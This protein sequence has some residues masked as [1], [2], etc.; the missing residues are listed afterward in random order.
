MAADSNSQGVSTKPDLNWATV[1]DSTVFVVPYPLF[2]PAGLAEKK[3]NG[4]DV[5]EDGLAFQIKDKDYFRDKEKVLVCID[6]F[7]MGSNRLYFNHID[8]YGTK[9]QIP[10]TKLGDAQWKRAIIQLEKDSF[11]QRASLYL[12]SDFYLDASMWA[13]RMY[14]DNLFISRI[15]L[16]G[17]NPKS[18]SELRTTGL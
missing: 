1:L 2:F 11:T 7:D 14:H 3:R 8:Q 13:G 4:G 10:I 6:Y 5:S 18:E 9:Q 15:I 17:F 16:K 12:G